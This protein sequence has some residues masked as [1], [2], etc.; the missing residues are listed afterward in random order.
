[1][2]VLFFIEFLISVVEADLEFKSVF[3]AEQF[4]YGFKALGTVEIVVI[5]S[6]NV[7]MVWEFGMV[8]QEIEGVV[9]C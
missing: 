7:S 4:C 9:K 3:P 1:M 6:Y 5:K 2:C 8:F